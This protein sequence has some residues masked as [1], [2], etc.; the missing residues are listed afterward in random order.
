MQPGEKRLPALD[1]L[2]ASAILMVIACHLVPNMDGGVRFLPVV[3][4]TIENLL[5]FGATGV[6]LFFVLSGFLIGRIIIKELQSSPNLNLRGFLWRRWMRTF[7]AY[8]VT[9]AFIAASDRI[10]DPVNPGN[11]FPAYLFF[12]QNY[13]TEMKRF[14]WSWSLCI[15]EHFYVA[16]P[17]LVIGLRT[18]FPLLAWKH[19]LRFLAAAAFVASNASRFWMWTT[20]PNYDWLLQGYFV[21]HYHLD[22]LACGVFVA[23]LERPRSAR[24]IIAL[25]AG[26]L[27]VLLVTSWFQPWPTS[28][29]RGALGFARDIG[30]VVPRGTRHLMGPLGF[31]LV[32][33][34]YGAL[35]HLSAGGNAWAR[36][37]PPGARFV[38]DISYSLYLTHFI[39]IRFF[40][41]T[42][43]HRL[44]QGFSPLLVLA[45]LALCF[46]GGTGLRYCVEIPF[47]KL[48]D[49]WE[50][51]VS[52]RARAPVPVPEKAV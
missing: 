10:K 31:T 41:R 16:L 50:P 21:T 2:R 47:L 37:A 18:A 33:V 45:A 35:V 30:L 8:Y 11:F 7:P 49:R 46:A 40:E 36:W 51:V 26:A 15:E 43:E 6:D 20:N 23:T 52:G 27:A 13:F 38:A 28:F 25:A 3:P 48:R 24:A 42:F 39:V 34:A 29:A 22:G 19:L 17:L 1:T 32:S 14:S 12:G 44:A 9:L 4:Q 5:H